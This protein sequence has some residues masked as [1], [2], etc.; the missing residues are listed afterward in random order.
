MTIST[1]L[2]EVA[3][4]REL[5]NGELLFL[6]ESEEGQDKILECA[7]NLNR[8]AHYDV[9]TFVHN[10]NI[11]YTNIC[12]NNCLFCAYRRGENDADAYMLSIEQVLDKIASAPGISEVCIQGGIKPGLSF[13]FIL[14]MLREIKAIYP[15]IHIHAF[16]PMEI[17]YFSI[18]SGHSVSSVINKLMACGLGSMPGTAAEILDDDV[19]RRICPQKL[20]TVEWVDIISSAHRM[21]LRSTATIL[22]GHLESVAQIVK[23]LDIIRQIQKETGGFTEFI[24]LV[25]MPYDTAL[26]R[27]FNIREPLSFS[28][29]IR[30]HAISRIYFHGLINNIQVSWPKLG[31][32]NAIKCLSAGVNDLGG[33]LYEENITRSAGG[34]Y[35]QRVSLEEFTERIVR[36]GKTPRMR[37][38]LYNLMPNSIFDLALVRNGG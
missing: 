26:G 5:A 13:S 28:R 3:S 36:A 7:D 10:R 21:G 37:D 2:N 20:S 34:N 4:G 1:I 19:R 14:E 9:V 12:G 8:Q 35:G 23:H 17:K 18:I 29:V 24:P 25:F 33:T 6:L 31:L 32:E 11:N 27:K 22:F 16:S 30:F 15:H 38:T